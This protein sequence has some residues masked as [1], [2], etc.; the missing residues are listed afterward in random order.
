M[1]W[2]R[3]RAARHQAAADALEPPACRAAPGCRGRRIAAI[4]DDIAQ[5]EPT[6]HAAELIAETL[7][8]GQA[9]PDVLLRAS[10]VATAPRDKSQRVPSLG[11]VLC[12]VAVPRDQAVARDLPLK[13][14]VLLV[15]SGS[16]VR[17]HVQ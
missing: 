8:E 9:A 15:L 13:A 3:R 5:I 17:W 11:A 6:P 4:T 7:K 12:D 10:Q 2:S 14:T 1:R 16:T